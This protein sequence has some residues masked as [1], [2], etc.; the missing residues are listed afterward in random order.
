MNET[1]QRIAIA[2]ACGIKT[3]TRGKYSRHW[4][5][6]FF[7]HSPCNADNGSELP[8]YL[9]DANTSQELID[10]LWEKGY[11]CVITHEGKRTDCHFVRRENHHTVMISRTG[12]ASG[13]I[14]EAFLKTLGLWEE[15]K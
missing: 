8:D 12:K 10:H 7:E 5:N 2:K 4:R 9:N 3:T 11:S 1:E 15:S 14:A 6:Q 13:I